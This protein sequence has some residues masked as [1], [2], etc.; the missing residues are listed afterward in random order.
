MLQNHEYLT[1]KDA[2]Q[3]FAQMYPGVPAIHESTIRKWAKSRTHPLKAL[4]FGSR[5]V[6]SIESFDKLIKDGW[7]KAKG[8]RSHQKFKAKQAEK[9]RETEQLVKV[10]EQVRDDY[11]AGKTSPRT[12]SD[13][14]MRAFWEQK[15][16]ERNGTT[17]QIDESV[18]DAGFSCHIDEP[19]T[20]KLV[21]VRRWIGAAQLNGAL[22]IC[23]ER[24]HSE[25][26]HVR[27]P[28][29]KG[30]PLVKFGQGD[31]TVEYHEED[32]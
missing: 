16:R 26:E 15:I 17:M 5:T 3:R 23:I 19:T 8:T 6:I 24:L 1:P 18:A 2:A 11:E 22:R 32:C 27:K 25:L 30:V 28:K 21:D 7:P 13:E 4:R 29:K 9:D 14:E 12:I 10:A 20:V 31:H